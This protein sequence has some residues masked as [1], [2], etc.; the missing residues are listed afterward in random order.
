MQPL[1]ASARV[2]RLLLRLYSARFRRAYGAEMEQIF[3]RRLSRAND[4]GTAAFVYALAQAYAD[5]IV[6]AV[7]E[8]FAGPANTTARRDSMYAI[9]ARDLTLRRAHVRAPAGILRHRRPHAG[10]RNRRRHGHRLSRGRDDSPA[11]SV[12]GRRSAGRHHG[13]V[14]PVREGAVPALPCC[15]TSA[16]T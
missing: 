7:S 12:S 9:I 8:R 13:R 5:L 16:S 1:H 15:A 3:C 10:A 11:A 14:A 2:F 4:R 6:S